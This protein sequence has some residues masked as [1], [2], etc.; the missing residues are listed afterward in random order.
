MKRWRAYGLVGA[1]TYIGIVEAKTKE[2]AIEKAFDCAD[3]SV[4]HQCART[5]S[6]PEVTGVEVEEVLDGEED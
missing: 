6:D 3:V 1:S 5:L 2:E 4:C